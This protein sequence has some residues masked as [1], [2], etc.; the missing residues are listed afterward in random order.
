M[1]DSPLPLL[2]AEQRAWRYWFA[3][4]LAHI[5]FGAVVLLLAFL[6]F[7]LVRHGLSPQSAMAG[8][9]AAFAV[10][11]M[12]LLRHRDIVEWLKTKTTY[13]RTG[14]VQAPFPDGSA[15]PASLVTLS[16]REAH[17][18]TSRYQVRSLVGAFFG[19]LAGGLT[20]F[21][22]EASAI[23]PDEAL[24]F[25]ANAQRRQMLALVLVTLAC[26]ATLAIGERR[27][28]GSSRWAWPAAGIFVGAAHGS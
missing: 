28:P 20:I 18:S 22:R 1:T 5:V 12:V 19:D 27:L 13:P 8:S 15:S 2:D 17:P 14:Y 26:A 6:N 4:G 7:C 3:D 9:L 21:P 16:L 25:E 11:S 23:Q 24:R 10:C